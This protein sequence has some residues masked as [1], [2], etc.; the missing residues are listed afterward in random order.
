[1]VV[2]AILENRFWILTHPAWGDVM[3]R[4]VEAKVTTGE[5]TSRAPG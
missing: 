3:R 1:M 5:L 2:D 4:R